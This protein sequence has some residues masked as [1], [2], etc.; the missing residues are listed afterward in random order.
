MSKRVVRSQANHNSAM[1]HA[2]QAA[3]RREVVGEMSA[4]CA[5][6]AATSLGIC[7]TRSALG[8]RS[9]LTRIQHAAILAC[10]CPL[11]VSKYGCSSGP[12][13]SCSRTSATC[14]SVSVV[15]P[16]CLPV[17]FPLPTP[18]SSRGD[19]TS[20]RCT[21]RNASTVRF[22]SVSSMTAQRHHGKFMQSRRA[23]KDQ[24]ICQVSYDDTMRQGFACSC[25]VWCV[26]TA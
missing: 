15:W 13:R 7:G 22:A 3:R 11:Y 2:Q 17:D 21:A 4:P 10:V 12:D 9:A 16:E 26:P 25:I 5:A 23:V 1:A 20:Q 18:T 19:T 8:V 24:L 14:T 6:R